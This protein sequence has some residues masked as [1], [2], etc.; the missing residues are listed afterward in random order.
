[1]NNVIGSEILKIFQYVYVIDVVND[2]VYSF[3]NGEVVT[4]S[5]FFDFMQSITPLIHPDDVNNYFDNLSIQN[6]EKNDGKIIFDYRVKENDSFV[7]YTNFSKVFIADDNKLV[8]SAS[9]K[10][11]KHEDNTEFEQLKSKLNRMSFK[12]SDVI[13]KLYNALDVSLNVRTSDYIKT[14]LGQLINEF[15]EF[16]KQ[17]QNDMISQ[18]NRVKQ[19]LIIIDDD[20]IT[21]NLIKKTF[22]DEYDILMATNG[23]EAI[24]KFEEVGFT[25]IVGIFLDILMPVVDGFG[26]LEYLK[27]KNVLSKIPVI[28]ISGAEDKATR[29][30]VYQYNIADLLEKPFNLEIIK[31]RTKNLINLYMTSSSLN[32][33]VLSQHT[34]LLEIVNKIVDS[35]KADNNATIL[36]VRKYFEVILN[37]VIMDYPEYKLEDYIVNKLLDA[38]VLYNVGIY[39]LPRKIGNGGYYTKDEIELI[40]KHPIYAS[41]IAKNYLSQNMD[42]ELVK[43]S[44]N[45]LLNYYENYDGSGYPNGI[46]GDD[47]PIYSQCLALAVE[48][49]DIQS[50]NPDINDNK[51]IEL[52]SKKSETKYNPKLI[53]TLPIIINMLK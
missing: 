8:I 52:V 10:N 23:Q 18:V 47:I 30:R 31:Y 32:S 13:F 43:L 37:Q 34:E 50:K 19:S 12:V 25:N 11:D 35:Y 15:P 39:V 27:D 38:S 4:T 40:K 20:A 28:T 14:L 48:V 53:D 36:K 1:M 22:K 44:T 17:V 3:S 6:I 21:R 2:K 33:M 46:S 51:I 41:Y 26:V 49:Y 42:N 45:L 29:Q 9:F 16:D 24:N 5:T 7:K